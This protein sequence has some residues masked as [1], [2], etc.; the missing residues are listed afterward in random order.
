MELEKF[1]QKEDVK[2]KRIFGGIAMPSG[3][4]A[5]F[6]CLIG[7]THEIGYQGKRK[8]V[9]LDEVEEW[10][11]SLTGD[12]GPMYLVSRRSRYHSGSVF[13]SHISIPGGPVEGELDCD[14]DVDLDDFALFADCITGV[15]GDVSLTECAPADYDG[16]NDVDLIDVAVFQRLFGTEP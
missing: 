7:E 3:N 11:V 14:G 2:Y 1:P 5:G 15:G 9:F 6:A 4:A 13:V 8:Y 16:D 12:E 10:D